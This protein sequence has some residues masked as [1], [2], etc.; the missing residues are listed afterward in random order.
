MPIGAQFAYPCLCNIVSDVGGERGFAHAGP[1]G[2]DD[3]IRGLQAAHLGVEIGQAG[4]ETRQAAV[5]LIGASS[6][7]D[8]RGEGMSEAL[9]TR[10]VTSRFGDFIEF[11]LGILDMMLRRRFDRRVVSEIDHIF[12]DGDQVAADR[13][14]VDRAP[15]IFGIDDRRRFGGEPRQVLIERKARDVKIRREERLQCHWRRQLVGAHQAGS[16]LKNTLMD[17]LE[18]MLRLKKVGD[19]I[20]RLVVDEDG[21]EQRLLSLYVMRRRAERRFRRNLSAC[22][23]IK[24]CHGPG[25]RDSRV[26]NL[27]M[28]VLG[29]LLIADH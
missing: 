29:F 16:K 1:A 19:P 4:G 26:A 15:V 25:S 10:I 12:A 21:A 18:E 3:Q 28:A 2:Q 23:R 8:R 14:V 22:G 17:R 11:P 9:E 7:I 13:Q 6:H 5:A 20:K 24:C 27:R